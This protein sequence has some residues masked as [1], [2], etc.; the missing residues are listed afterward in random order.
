MARV[1]LV[2]SDVDHRHAADFQAITQRKPGVVQITGGDL[3]GTKV[4]G[5]LAKLVVANRGV[6]L[7]KGH[8]EILVFHLPGECIFKPLPQ[9]QRRVD[10]PFVAWNEKW[11]E[12]RKTLD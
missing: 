6:E 9:T 10:V 3:N 11:R 8:R 7:S 1:R 12:K 5:T 2:I 4:K